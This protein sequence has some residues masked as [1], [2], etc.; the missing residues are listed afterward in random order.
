MSARILLAGAE[1]LST[2][3][4]SHIL[5]AGS[6]RSPRPSHEF[7]RYHQ[8][9]MLPTKS[10]QE[11]QAVRLHKERSPPP[12]SR[13][14]GFI[15]LNCPRRLPR[16]NLSQRSKRRGG[17]PN[18]CYQSRS[19]YFP[20]P[21]LSPVVLPVLSRAVAAPV[22][23]AVLVDPATTVRPVAPGTDEFVLGVAPAG[24]GVLGAPDW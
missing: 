6:Q 20:P 5:F 4:S 9:A 18:G 12:A 7:S 23:A 1:G 17:A 16:R 2:T 24:D 21:P 10:I 19:S 22:P 8:P 14:S 3:R 11:S 13:P 15:P